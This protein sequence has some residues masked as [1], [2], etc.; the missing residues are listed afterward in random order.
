MAATSRLT[1]QWLM[2]DIQGLFAPSMHTGAGGRP[3]SQRDFESQYYTGQV[4]PWGD[5]N[6]RHY[7]SYED[8]GDQDVGE[9]YASG[10]KG[11]TKIEGQ[12]AGGTQ[13][14][15]GGTETPYQDEISGYEFSSVDDAY[16]AYLK[17][18]GYDPTTQTQEEFTSQG[19]ET[20]VPFG[21]INPFDRESMVSGIEAAHGMNP[22]DIG[23]SRNVTELT[24]EMFRKLRPEY[25]QSDVT[26]GRGSLLGNLLKK[27]RLSKE[28]GSGLAGYG[29][30][31][32]G[33]SEAETQYSAG[34]EDVYAGIDQQRA[35]ALQSIYDVVG[36]YSDL[37]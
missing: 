12:I 20:V 28:K 13:G 21:S 31:Q 8:W 36:D 4:D 15:I 3:L 1:P 30:R 18:L 9:L 19:V 7:F 26:E 37:A 6:S 33:V 23:L 17:S 24:P 16:E 2:Q 32:R 27:V 10:R 5:D 11:H 35:S 29:G 14:W 25:Y 34:M 22:A